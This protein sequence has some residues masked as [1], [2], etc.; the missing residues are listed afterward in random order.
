MQGPQQIW[1]GSDAGSGPP[2]GSSGRLAAQA[3]EHQ[4]E[5]GRLV[6]RT[7][8]RYEQVQSQ[9]AQG[10][11]IKTIV[12]DLGLARETVLRF[13][14]ARNV[15][16]LLATAQIGS[17]PS[18]LDPFTDHLHQRWNEGCTSATELFTEILALGY[19]GTCATLRGYLRPFRTTAGPPTT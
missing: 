13:A 4:A 8:Q 3:T 7:R 11:G 12:R 16:D 6:D 18:I 1:L 10:M 5:Q 17:R 9:L 15:Q 2:P 19:R 14:R